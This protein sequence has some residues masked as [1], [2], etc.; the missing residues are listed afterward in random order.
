MK[1]LWLKILPTLRDKEAFAQLFV[2]AAVGVM[3]MGGAIKNKLS[4]LDKFTDFFH[5]L[6]IPAAAI[7]APMVA[8]LELVCGILLIIG[9]GT[10]FAAA[11]LA[12]TMVVAIGTAATSAKHGTLKY[13]VEKA[14]DASFIDGVLNFIYMPEFLLFAILVWFV[15]A[16][17]GR[18]SVDHGIARQHN[19]EK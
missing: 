18:F 14:F 19:L 4:N 13:S 3:F 17:P 2:R 11:A 12:G 8:I 7:Q 5:E 16:G 15:F 9:L 10:R 1:E 6:G